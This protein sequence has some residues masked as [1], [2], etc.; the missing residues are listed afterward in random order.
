ML[1]VGDC[2]E[3]EKSMTQLY[4][5]AL[6]DGMVYLGACRYPEFSKRYNLIIVLYSIDGVLLSEYSLSV[7]YD[8]SGVDGISRRLS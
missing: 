4:S 5:T 3:L 1:T 2:T 8:L 6:G 7:I